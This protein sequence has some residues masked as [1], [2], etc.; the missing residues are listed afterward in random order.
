MVIKRFT[1]Q[2][3][4]RQAARAEFVVGGAVNL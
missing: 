3:Q 2:A 1:I 4:M